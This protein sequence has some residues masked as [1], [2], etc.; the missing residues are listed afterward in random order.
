MRQLTEQ[1]IRNSFLNCSKG[2]AKRLNLPVTWPNSPGAT[3][4]S[5]AGG[6]SRPRTAPTSSPS[7][8][9]VRRGS[10]CAARPLPHGRPGAASAPCASPPTP[11][12]SPSWSRRRPDRPVAR[13]TRWA[14]TCAVTWPA[15]CTCEGARTRAPLPA[16]RVAHPGGEDSAHGVERRRLHRQGDGLTARAGLLVRRGAARCLSA[17]SPH[18]QVAIARLPVRHAASGGGG[19]CGG[20]SGRTGARGRNTAG[21]LGPDRTHGQPV[22]FEVTAARAARI[23]AQACPTAG[24]TQPDGSGPCALSA[25]AW[26]WRSRSAPP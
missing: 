23:E 5:S 3:W 12:G 26:R 19:G 9:A 25:A 16:A 18:R 24:A 14:R 7:S 1:D 6:T 20:E 15:R 22:G 2:E 8:T 4:T 13:A 10:Y 11:A 21:G 17:V